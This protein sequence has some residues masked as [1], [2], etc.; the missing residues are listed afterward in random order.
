V[1]GSRTR[2]QDGR[3]TTASAAIAH[4]ALALWGVQRRSPEL[5]NLVA[6]YLLIGNRP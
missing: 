5:A 3:A 1:E 2:I 6:R 4:I